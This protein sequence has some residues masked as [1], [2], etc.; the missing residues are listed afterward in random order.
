MVALALEL[1]IEE[2]SEEV[3]E[4]VK[5]KKASYLKLIERV[6][7]EAKRINKEGYKRAK[8]EVKLA[9]TAAK[10]TAFGSLYEDFG[11]KDVDKKLYKLAKAKEMKAHDL[12][13]VKCIKDEEGRVLIE[14]AHIRRR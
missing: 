9:V 14:E 13:Q 4:K 2:W 11:A 3:Q 8:K 6:N 12:D 10:T 7:E 1:R 5:A